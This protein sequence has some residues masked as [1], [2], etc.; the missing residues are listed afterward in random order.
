M[1]GKCPVCGLATEAAVCP[2]CATILLPDQA[3]CPKCG[4]MFPGRIAVCDACG[5]GVGGDLDDAEED[6]VK[7]FSLVPGMDERTARSLYA[8]GFR[9]FADV[10]KLGLPPS[11]VKRG[12]HHTISRKILLSSIAPKATEKVGRTTCLACHATV[13]ETES[14]CPVCG[15]VLG[16]AAEQ[17]FIEKKLAEVQG[18]GASL[19]TDP[20]FLSM[21]QAVRE[22]ILREMGTMLD[23]AQGPGADDE[24]HLQIEAWR[25]KGFDVEPVLLLLA[26]H[27]S[28]FRDRAVRLIRAQ[29]RKKSEGGVFRCPLCDIALEATAEECANC[30]AKFA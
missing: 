15:A 9:D 22:E 13:L 20:D 3:I 7:V 24:F 18:S 19:A 11:A 5:T 30:G 14:H 25:A 12:L 10:V 23:E 16:P 6:A 8:R 29:I 26:Q 2:R 1:A 21:P 27:P 4:K 17:A 28:N